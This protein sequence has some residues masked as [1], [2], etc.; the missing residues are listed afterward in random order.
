[1][2]RK[3]KRRLRLGSQQDNIDTIYTGIDEPL[4]R[5]IERQKRGLMRFFPNAAIIFKGR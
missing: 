2:F 5:N 4:P 3:I 1:M